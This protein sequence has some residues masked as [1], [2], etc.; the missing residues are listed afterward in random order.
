MISSSDGTDSNA[1][2][3]AELRSRA[4]CSASRKILP[5]YSRSPSQTAS[6]PC[7]AESNGLIAR[8]VAVHEL[9]V[10]VD[11]QVAVALVEGLQHGVSS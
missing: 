2:A 4:R 10:D 3:A 8:L 6:P 7:T 1:S 5:W 11:D 9:P